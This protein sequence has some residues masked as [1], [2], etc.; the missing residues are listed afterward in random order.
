MLWLRNSCES[1]LLVM[2]EA[3]LV[4]ISDTAR[5]L[6]DSRIKST[7]AALLGLHQR[8]R[9]RVCQ[10]VMIKAMKALGSAVTSGATHMLLC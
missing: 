4:S 8:G 9:W 5:V 10:E 7:F 3:D 1:E 6:S 2:S